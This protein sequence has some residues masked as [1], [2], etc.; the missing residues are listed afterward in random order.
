MKQPISPAGEPLEIERKFLIR[1]PAEQVLERE[2]VRRIDIEQVYLARRQKGESRRIRQSR[3]DG[4]TH[5]YYNEKVRLSP[6]TRIERETEITGEEYAALC[7]EADPARQTI[8]KTRWLVPAGELTLEVDVF[9]FWENQAFCE[10]ELERE[11]QPVALPDWMEL[12]R[13]VTADEHYTNNAMAKHIPPEEDPAPGVDTCP[14]L[15]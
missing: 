12:I 2:S 10:A 1:R 7:R 4:E 3:W 6:I 9:P 8:R 15:G 11:D 14:G 13:E 5:Y